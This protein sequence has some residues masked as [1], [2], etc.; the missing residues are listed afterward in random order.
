[1]HP[2]DPRWE[3]TTSANSPELSVEEVA[4]V[5]DWVRSGGGLL[6][7]SEYE[8]DKYGDNLNEL[9][10]P[11]GLGLANGKVFDRSACAH[12]NAEWFIAGSVPGHPLSHGVRQPCFYRAGWCTTDDPAK[13]AWR[14]SAHAHPARSAVIAAT[15]LGEGRIV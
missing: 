1:P 5:R 13:I 7:I 11:T 15:K 12:D 10:A 3:R 9:L 2:C 14:T 4:A 8:H 6:V